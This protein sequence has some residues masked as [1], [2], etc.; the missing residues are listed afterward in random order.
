MA[1]ISEF[2]IG[3]GLTTRPSEKEEIWTKRY[4]EFTVK[5]PEQFT[6]KDL[7]DAILAAEYAIDNFLGQ[8]ATPATP[9]IP[10]FDPG[11][12]MNRQGWKA[13]KKGDGTYESGSLSWGWDFADKFSKEII[14]ALERGPIEI[15]K[16]VFSLNKER[17]LV[18]VKK[19]KGE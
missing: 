1:K 2:R 11:L 13:K 8:P 10:E 6:D 16:Y 12:L 4:L 15:D 18:S 5:M 14:Q 19:K 7:Q 3:K 9:Q 17:T